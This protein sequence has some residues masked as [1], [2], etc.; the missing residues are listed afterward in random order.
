MPVSYSSL[1]DFF[2][3][4]SNSWLLMIIMLFTLPM[5]ILSKITI[6]PYHSPLSYLGTYLKL[7]L[8]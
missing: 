1:T 4:P 3:N 6:I 7:T 5:K 8:G 2:L